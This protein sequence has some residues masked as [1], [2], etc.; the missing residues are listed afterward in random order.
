MVK[1]NQQNSQETREVAELIFIVKNSLNEFNTE[2]NYL[3]RQGWQPYSGVSTD[4]LKY[5]IEMRKYK[6]EK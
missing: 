3:L 2:I 4:D 5:S 1:I 6:E